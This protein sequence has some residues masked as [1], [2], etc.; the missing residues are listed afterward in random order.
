MAYDLGRAERIRV[1]LGHLGNFSERKMF[2]GLCFLL[3]GRMCC[4]IM[5]SDLMLRLG[6]ALPRSC[7]GAVSIFRIIQ[8]S[9]KRTLRLAP[10]LQVVACQGKALI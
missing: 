8:G 1:V 10:A 2:G 5:K 4:G 6:E 9:S 3:N 7:V